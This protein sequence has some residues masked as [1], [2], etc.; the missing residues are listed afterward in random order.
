MS[1]TLC[2]RCGTAIEDKKTTPIACPACGH[3]EDTSETLFGA[4]T[5]QPA[6][7]FHDRG[8]VKRYGARSETLCACELRLQRAQP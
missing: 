5:V 8:C 7:E 4:V 3:I 6:I 1:L 2:S